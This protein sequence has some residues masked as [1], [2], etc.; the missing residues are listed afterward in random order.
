MRKYFRVWKQLAILS[1]SSYFSNRIEYGSYFVGKIL[2]FLFFLAMILAI[3]SHTKSLAGYSKYQVIIFFLTAFL[4]DSLGQ[5]F[6]R[7]IY[8]FRQDVQKANLD[9]IISKPINPLFFVLTRST[10]I[11][12]IF[13]LVP[14]ILLIIYVFFKLGILSSFLALLLYTLFIG[15]SL[16]ITSA[17]HIMSAATTIFTMDSE[18]FIW[19]YRSS[20]FAALFPPE[21]FPRSV[22]HIFTFVMPIVVVVA[23][24]AKAVLGLITL[25]NTLVGLAVAFVFFFGSLL[26]WK[27]ALKHYSSASS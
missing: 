1:I 12:D 16:L 23:F 11:L 27:T 18:T 20:L 10:D 14:V 21:I 8:L 9:Y 3:F 7:G 22:Q 24:P 2:R 15:L 13:F 17:L 6:F 26:L 25:Q 5:A 4:V 19:L